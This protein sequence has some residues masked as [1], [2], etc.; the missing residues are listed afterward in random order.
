MAKK[1]LK[2]MNRGELVAEIRQLRHLLARQ[3][4]GG[5]TLW[6]ESGVNMDGEA[7]V[8]MHWGKE[9][10]QLTPAKAREH[11]TQMIETATAAD[12]DAKLFKSLTTKM[13]LDKPT[14]AAF[15]GDLR[16]DRGDE[17]ESSMTRS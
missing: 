8:H 2:D 9:S 17:R 5:E 7:F 16:E 14:A 12:F 3:M 4:S 6:M 15:I 1:N 13:G 11:A 10:G